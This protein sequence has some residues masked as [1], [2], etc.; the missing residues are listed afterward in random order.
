MVHTLIHVSLILV[1]NTRNPFCRPQQLSRR[2]P[3]SPP[4]TSLVRSACASSLSPQIES[5][6]RRTREPKD[7]EKNNGA[8]RGGSEAEKNPTY[9]QPEKQVRGRGHGFLRS[10]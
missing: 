9:G 6:W 3:P 2:P 7:Q 1:W 5:R 4:P 10:S 8:R